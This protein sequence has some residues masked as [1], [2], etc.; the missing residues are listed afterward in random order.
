VAA[1]LPFVAP[2]LSAAQGLTTALGIGLALSP[3]IDFARNYAGRLKGS[4][5]MSKFG[6]TDF[7]NLPGGTAF[8]RDNRPGDIDKRKKGKDPI[9]E[10]EGLTKQVVPTPIESGVGEYQYPRVE[11]QTEREKETDRMVDLILNLPET[12]AEA[13]AKVDYEAIARENFRRN[14]PALES[15]PEEE[16]FLFNRYKRNLASKLAKKGVTLEEAEDN[17]EQ[18]FLADQLKKYKAEKP[19]TRRGR[20]RGF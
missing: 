18:A 8:E 4:S 2:A 20:Q 12:K 1:I 19:D 17:P 3:A 10:I 9:A 6:G 5:R 7:T 11:A 15:M 16:E 13:D 14:N